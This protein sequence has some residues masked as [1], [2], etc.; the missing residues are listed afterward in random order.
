MPPRDRTAARVLPPDPS[1]MSPGLAML[2][3]VLYALPS[4]PGHDMCLLADRLAP[5][6]SRVLE[7]VADEMLA[8]ANRAEITHRP[9]LGDIRGMAMAAM[10]ARHR[11]LAIREEGIVKRVRRMKTQSALHRQ[12][13]RGP[14]R[15]ARFRRRS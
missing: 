9:S 7:L 3:R 4:P 10:E 6:P 14:V 8:A 12:S 11:L 5:M 13:P 1:K 2:L 15:T